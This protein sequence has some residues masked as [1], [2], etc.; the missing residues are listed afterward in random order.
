MLCH[1]HQQ[2][3]TTQFIKDY[4][5]RFRSLDWSQHIC[6]SF[7]KDTENQKYIQRKVIRIT[8]GQKAISIK[9]YGKSWEWLAWKSLRMK[10]I[11]LKNVMDNHSKWEKIYAVVS[12]K[13]DENK[14]L[15]RQLWAVHQCSERMEWGLPHRIIQIA[16]NA[17]EPVRDD[18]EVTC[19][20]G[21]L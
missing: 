13:A 7:W 16:V 15:K 2:M 1:C 9:E 17:G 19:D 10:I 8:A 5:T 11:L 6:S 4:F 21:K 12:E 20:L 18:K 3:L 14:M